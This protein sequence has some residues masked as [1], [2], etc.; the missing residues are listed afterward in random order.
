MQ[1]RIFTIKPARNA[2]T[3]NYL[4]MR[5]S[6]ATL[7]VKVCTPR[8]GT[9]RPN[10]AYQDAHQEIKESLALLLLPCHLAV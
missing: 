5:G 3:L 4:L 7:A 1:Y 10:F 2:V 6:F 9:D 8:T